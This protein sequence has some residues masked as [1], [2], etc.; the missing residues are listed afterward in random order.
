M[1]EAIVKRV[2]L[3]KN[4]NQLWEIASKLIERINQ[5]RKGT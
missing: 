5:N 2:K 3:I 4:F 1:H